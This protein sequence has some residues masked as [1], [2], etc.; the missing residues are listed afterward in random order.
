MS[1]RSLENTSALFDAHPTDAHDSMEQAVAALL[2]DQKACQAWHRYALI[3]QV[4]RGEDAVTTQFDISAQVLAKISQPESSV[5][6]EGK[7]SLKQRFADLGERWLRP[8]ASV[9]IAA[10]VA[11][12]AVVAVQQPADPAVDS[13]SQPAF[14]TQPY[15]ANL[16][17][18]SL[19][20]VVQEQSPS[21]AEVAKQRQLLQA[22]ML[23]H[24][25]QLQLSMQEQQQN[26]QEEA[27]KQP[28]D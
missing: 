27:P 16:T 23:D 19:N 21:A 26:D 14:V 12:F 7:R 9:G 10:S 4:M 13:Y 24:Q 18:V 22:Y 28:N 6:V 17:P 8:A 2:E 15:G 5:V 20:T 25:R 1:E 3:G 11:M